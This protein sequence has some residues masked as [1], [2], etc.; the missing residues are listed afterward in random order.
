MPFVIYPMLPQHFDEVYSLW[1]SI[2]G[3]ELNPLDDNPQ[4]ISQFLNFNSDL[5]YIALIE[6]KI[7]GVIMCGFDGRRAT[8]YHLAVNPKHR[9]KGIASTLLSTLEQALKEKG[10]TKGRLLAFKT[11]KDAAYFWQRQGWNLQ[12]QLN[13]FSKNFV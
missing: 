9:R 2:Y 4:T 5:N 8:V 1:Q 3:V 11:N 6:G 7:V 10:I 12:S 13:Y